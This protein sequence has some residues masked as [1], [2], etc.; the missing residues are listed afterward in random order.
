M[1]GTP[2]LKR[3][4]RRSG[5]TA[6]AY[7]ASRAWRNITDHPWRAVTIAGAVAVGVAVAIAIIA[8]SDGINTKVTDLLSTH[9]QVDL[10]QYGVDVPTIHQ[11]LL[12]TR[13]LLTK[14]AI[15]FTAALVGL[16]TWTT[17]GQRR[18]EIGIYVQQGFHRG[19][20]ITEMLGE[21]L[22]L[23]VVGGVAGVAL[24]VVLCGLIH[25]QIPLL[26]MNP[27]PSGVLVIFPSTTLLSFTATASIAAFFVRLRDISVGL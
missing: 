1:P 2:G 25:G 15:A 5:I 11:V 19:E 23:C 4:K 8:A 3:R 21:S 13:D 20:I 26:P 22:C 16:V 12:Q 18:R 14:L 17:M 9:G 6:L 24:G 7:S 10:S 27:Q